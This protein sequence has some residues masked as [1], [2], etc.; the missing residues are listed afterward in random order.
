MERGRFE[1]DWSA[2]TQ[3]DYRSMLDAH[4]L[5]RFG[6]QRIEAIT[7]E[8]IEGWRDNL[9]NDS[10][11]SRRTVNKIVTQMHSVYE[12]AVEGSPTCR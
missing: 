9:A 4:L 11:R 1:R 10:K 6:T 12:Y 7:A 2:S 5:P 3:I 8:E